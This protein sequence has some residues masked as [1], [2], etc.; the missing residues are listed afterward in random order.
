MRRGIRREYKIKSFSCLEQFLCLAFAQLTS[1]E[2]RI[3]SLPRGQSDKLYHM[4]IRSGFRAAR[5][6]MQRGARLAHHAASRSADRDGRK[7]YVDEPSA[8][9]SKDG[10]RSRR[11]DHRSVL[12]GFVGSVSHDKAAVKLHTLL[13]LRAYPA[14]IHIS[15][16][17]CT[18]SHPRPVARSRALLCDGPRY[19]DFERLFIARAGSL[20]SV[21]VQPEGSTSLFASGDRSTGHLRSDGFLTGFYSSQDFETPAP[22]SIQR[23]KTGKRLYFLTNNSCCQ[24]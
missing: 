14:F 12:V 7:L 5:W 17:R 19:L 4:G 9:I 8:S 20:L 13:D 22:D 18:R 21:A 10:L 23:S 1:R 11:D 15:D 16:G 24:P 6:R 3:S 2:L